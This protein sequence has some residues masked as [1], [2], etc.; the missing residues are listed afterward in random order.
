MKQGSVSRH[1]QMG[2]RGVVLVGA[3]IAAVF[4]VGLA[5]AESQTQTVRVAT[6]FGLA[7]LPLIVM[8]HDRLWEKRAEALGLKIAVDYLRLGGGGALNDALISGSADVSAGGLAPMLVLW[9]KTRSSF[10]VKGLAALNVSPMYILTNK[11]RIRSLRD[12]G[13]EDKI[14]VPA[15]RVSIQAIA[16]MAACEQ[17]FGAGQANRLDNL[18]VAMQHPDALIAL[19]APN[20]QISAYVSSSP[21]QERA[22][23]SPG[24]AKITDSFEA[25]G[26]PSTFSVVYAKESFATSNPK[27]VAAFYAALQDALTS[28]RNDHRGAIDKYLAVTKERTERT[29]LED[30]LNRPDFTFGSEP[31]GTLPIAELMH[32]V[33]L[34]KNKP[35]SWKDFFAPPLHGAQGS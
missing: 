29:L 13:P 32:R 24:I 18:T 22:L 9:D 19:T 20:S 14:A 34:L 8:E 26:G 5:R 3:G 25:F 1:W 27:I 35:A 4:L 16:L 28:I 7:Y 30:I 15:I 12:L 17:V 21:F 10:R 6:Q 33:G 31:T 11:P 2:R 23:K